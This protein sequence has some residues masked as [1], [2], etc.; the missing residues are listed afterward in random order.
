MARPGQVIDD[1]TVELFIDGK[2]KKHRKAS[3]Q[4]R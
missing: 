2:G 3:K 4:A 1:E